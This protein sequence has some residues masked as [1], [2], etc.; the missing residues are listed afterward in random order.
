[1]LLVSTGIY[2]GISELTTQILPFTKGHSSNA[3]WHKPHCAYSSTVVLLVTHN[4]YVTIQE[5]S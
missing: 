2:I 3:I 4:V 5:N 1:M